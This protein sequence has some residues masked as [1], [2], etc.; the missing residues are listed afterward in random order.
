MRSPV[1]R[2]NLRRIRA[3]LD[4]ATIR[5][6]D[7][8]P[9]AGSAP[10]A[11]VFAGSPGSL[12]AGRRV[13]AVGDIHGRLT[14]LRALH[15]AIAEDIA[16][17]PVPAALLVHLGDYI[18]W[19][20]DSAGVVALLAAG[21]PVAGAAV[22]NLIGDHEQMLLD[23]LAGDAAAATDWLHSGGREALASWGIDPATPRQDWKDRL[24]SA[25]LAFLAGLAPHHK[26][27]GYLFV[28]AG[29][30]PGVRLSAQTRM[31]LHS[32]R[33]PFLSSDRDLGVVVVHGHTAA[34]TPV[35]RSNR[36]GVDTG[37]ALGGKLTSAVL[38]DDRIGFIS[39]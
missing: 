38:E 36:V 19:G 33:E 24:P 39:V 13:Y 14:Q 17:R 2:P 35:V 25:H 31:D 8:A 26:A 4:A 11:I 28:H 27:G 5:T 7:A 32:I 20:P 18:D 37:A 29:V 3:E 9:L 34:S 1:R 23:A 12:P 10:G 15:A 21:P 22:V 6:W 16:R 30:R